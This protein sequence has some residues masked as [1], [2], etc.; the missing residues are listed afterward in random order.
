MDDQDLHQERDTPEAEALSARSR[1]LFDAAPAFTRHYVAAALELADDEM[2]EAQA[3]DVH[4]DVMTAMLED[5]RIFLDRH[6]TDIENSEDHVLERCSGGGYSAEEIAGTDFWLTRNGHG[7]G[8]WDGDWPELEG[9][10]MDE[11]AKEFGQQD[12]YLGDDGFLYASGGYVPS[13]A[14]TIVP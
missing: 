5:C 13:A 4:P 9:G 8:F 3:E 14:S 10:R 1:A 7:A 2:P 12:I 11:T 6:A